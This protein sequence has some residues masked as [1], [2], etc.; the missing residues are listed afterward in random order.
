MP[1]PPFFAEVP[2]DLGYE[3]A[4]LGQDVM[5]ALMGLPRHQAYD[6]LIGA[7]HDHDDH[8][9]PALAPVH[10]GDGHTEGAPGRGRLE[11]A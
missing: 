4:W 11:H 7:R 3:A 5:R 9:T 10:E 8:A 6:E 2:D 1:M